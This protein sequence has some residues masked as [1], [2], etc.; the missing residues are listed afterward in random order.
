ARRARR[1]RCG[2]RA[3]AAD[4]AQGLH[5]TRLAHGRGMT[6]LPQILESY[7]ATALKAIATARVQDAKL[8]R[9]KL[10]QVLAKVLWDPKEV[11]IF[12]ASLTPAQRT[13]LQRA[14]QYGGTGLRPDLLQAQI[15][16]DGIRDAEQVIN[17]LLRFGFLVYE[18]KGYGQWELWP[19]QSN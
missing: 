4:A 12:L 11:E 6:P 8:P 19:S 2:R 1:A 3:R 10:V 14:K 13:A 15:E 7:S 9:A 16:A 5:A 17:S 18:R